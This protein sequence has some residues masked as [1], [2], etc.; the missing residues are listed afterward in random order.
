MIRLETERLHLRPPRAEDVDELLPVYG[1]ADVM[2]YIAEGTPWS[3]E[4]TLL[5]LRRWISFWDDDGF[6]LFALER[7][8]DS[9]LLGDV[10]L[11]AWN[12]ESWTPG[13]VASIGP[14]AVIE[15][16]WT[17]ARDCW[18]QGYATEAALAVRE[19]AHEELGLNRLISL[20]HPDND[21]SIRVAEKLGERHETDVVLSGR[22][23][24]LYSMAL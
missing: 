24:R 13:S 19:W 17:L 16:G 5:A 12:T 22:P 21:A 23:A 1:D 11:L 2:R 20:I 3:R 10:G 15:I 9:R 14:S 18:G 7:R 8:A 6:G 4:R